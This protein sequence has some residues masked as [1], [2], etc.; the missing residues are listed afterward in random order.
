MA[1]SPARE[2]GGP[3]PLGAGDLPAEE[4]T[5]RAVVAGVLLGLVF[6]AANAYLGLRVGLTVSASIPAAVMAVAVVGR[7]LLVPPFES[8]SG[9]S[10]MGDGAHRAPRNGTDG[11]RCAPRHDAPRPTCPRDLFRVGEKRRS[12][13]R[14]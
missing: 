13:N 1:D 2:S 8:P 12:A 7:L 14:T 11:C 3:P 4:F 5:L 9:T 6:G 10:P